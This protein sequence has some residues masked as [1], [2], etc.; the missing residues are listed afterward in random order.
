MN[1]I[2]KFAPF[3]LVLLD[4]Y[5]HRSTKAGTGL[6]PA[7]N[8]S[9]FGPSPIDQAGLEPNNRARSIIGSGLGF[10]LAQAWPGPNLA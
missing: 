9:G 3:E 6:R 5:G 4:G 8:W 7:R 1:P 10:P 2:L